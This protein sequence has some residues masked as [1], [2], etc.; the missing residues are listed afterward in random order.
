MLVTNG[1]C[2]NVKVDE[3]RI[4][5]NKATAIVNGVDAFIIDFNVGLSEHYRA[6]RYVDS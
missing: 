5:D 4:L 3:W 6:E 1:A 2:Y